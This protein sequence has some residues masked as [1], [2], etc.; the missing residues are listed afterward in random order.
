[1]A[2]PWSRGWYLGDPPETKLG[3]FR[4]ST[5]MRLP[6]L[7][8]ASLLVMGI[9]LFGVEFLG[10]RAALV[11]ALLWMLQPHAFWHSHFACFDVPVTALWFFTAWAFLK[12]MPPPGEPRT[13]TTLRWAVLAA[14]FLGLALDT[15]HNA[16][17]FP[18]VAFLWWAWTRRKGF[19]LRLRGGGPRVR[20]PTI[21]RAFFAFVT[22]TPLVYWLLWPKLW[23]D[24]VEHLKWYIGFHSHHEYY[25]AYYFRTLY[26]KPPFPISFPFVMSALTMPGTTV[27]LFG[28]GALRLAWEWGLRQAGRVLVPAFE[29]AKRLP[30]R[31]SGV[32]LFVF[33]NFLIPFAVIAHPKVPIFGGTKHWLHGVPFLCLMAGVGFEFVLDGLRDLADRLGPAFRGRGVRVAGAVLAGALFV[34]PAAW[35]TLTD[36]ADGSSW[37]NAFAGGRAAMGESGMQR[38]FWGNSSYDALPWINENLPPNSRVDFHDSTWD[39]VRMYWRDGAL[40]RDVIPVWDFKGADVFLFH[41]HKEFTDLEADARAAFG[42]DAPAFVAAPGGVPLLD[43]WMR[44]GK[45]RRP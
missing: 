21:P 14:I 24:P 29:L 44:P 39:A 34:G 18:P 8:L 27:L 25:W 2:E 17:F 6:A 40:R 20:I 45:G 22:V 19:G 16:F 11:A 28:A 13:G 32:V 41:W 9:Y 31:E 10:R 15:K 43:A 35:D 7:L 3:W 4:E 23:H 30:A 42:A 12:S 33:L 38:E 1:V 37:Y 26:T 5:A 36:T